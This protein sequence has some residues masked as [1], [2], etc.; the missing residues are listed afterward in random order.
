MERNQKIAIDG[1]PLQEPPLEIAKKGI[2]AIAGYFEELD[3]ADATIPNLSM[4][5]PFEEQEPVGAAVNS[6]KAIEIRNK[7]ATLVVA[8]EVA[9]DPF[10]PNN[11]SVTDLDVVGLL[12]SSVT[13]INLA[14]CCFVTDVTVRAIA[15]N[16]R[17]LESI[18]V[19]K[20]KL[21]TDGGLM[22]LAKSCHD[23]KLIN[24]ISCDNLTDKTIR[25]IARNCKSL[26]SINVRTSNLLTDGGL[27]ELAENCHHLKSI[28]FRSA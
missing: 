18:D 13:R 14:G 23:L 8:S 22:D 11:E 4:S 12:H 28:D 16:C 27:A 25:A 15:R 10:Y 6:N 17:S 19:G 1:N 2:E 9:P 24:F 7:V 21:L 26:E 20:C 5:D 3:R